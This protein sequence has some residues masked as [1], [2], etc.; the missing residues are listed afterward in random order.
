[1]TMPAPSGLHFPDS[2]APLCAST[3]FSILP[4][5]LTR[6]NFPVERETIGRRVTH[7][8]D[9]ATGD[10]F[11]V[12]GDG[13]MQPNRKK[14]R[15]PMGVLLRAAKRAA[16]KGPKVRQINLIFETFERAKEGER[17]T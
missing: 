8:S 10:T 3:P 7:P 17:A 11:V 2:T 14:K 13:A 12:F 5:E 4:L 6:K 9:L 16:K 15:K 1:M